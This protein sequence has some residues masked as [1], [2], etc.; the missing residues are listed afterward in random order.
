MNNNFLIRNEYCFPGVYKFLHLSSEETYKYNIKKNKKQ[1]I[2][3]G[4]TADSISYN[5]NN[6]GYR[7]DE[8]FFEGDKCNVYLGCSYTIG[9]EVPYV[10]TWPYI[11]N[12]YLNDYKLYNL[13]ISGAGP[14]TC[15]RVLKGF[16][17]IVNIQ[18]VFLLLPNVDRREIFYRN[19]WTQ[20]NANSS[21]LDKHMILSLFSNEEIYTNKIKTLDAIRYVCLVNNIPLYLLDMYDDRL[22]QIQHNDRTARD[23]SHIGIKGHAQLAEMFINQLTEL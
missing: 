9:E 16:S 15:Y 10:N 6:Y 20:I 18:R 3:L 2:E 17:S 11:V 5:I 14:E 23:L 8:D 12:K 21:L 19:V 4:W 13:G 22:Q 1:L 7:S